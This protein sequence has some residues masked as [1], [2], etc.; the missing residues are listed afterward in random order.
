[1]SVH[2]HVDDQCVPMRFEAR[3]TLLVF[4]RTVMPIP[5]LH[6]ILRRQFAWWNRRVERAAVH[7]RPLEM[8][9]RLRALRPTPSE[10]RT[11]GIDRALLGG[12]DNNAAEFRRALERHSRYEGGFG[13]IL[14]GSQGMGF[15]RSE[16]TGN[17]A[18]YTISSTYADDRGGVHLAHELGHILGLND[19]YESVQRTV[20]LRRGGEYQSYSRPG[21]ERNIMGDIIRDPAYG[22][23]WLAGSQVSEMA[24]WALLAAGPSGRAQA[25]G[26]S[27]FATRGGWKWHRR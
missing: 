27:Y 13:A 20:P 22:R 12:G 14:V 4:E 18:H 10:E 5:N 19:E 21:M 7:G 23:P 25:H 9:F 3:V 8:R 11:P 15:G 6:R 2:W 1:M 26:V 16:A 17:V 24:D